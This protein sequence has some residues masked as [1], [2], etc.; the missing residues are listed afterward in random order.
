MIGGNTLTCRLRSHLDGHQQL[1]NLALRNKHSVKMEGSKHELI[2]SMNGERLTRWAYLV[3]AV[4]TLYV[5]E[6]AKNNKIPREV[7]TR[8]S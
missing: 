7:S 6:R 3:F 8:L 5:V 4:S 2:Q 1:R